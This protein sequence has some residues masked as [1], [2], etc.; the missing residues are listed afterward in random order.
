L[1][2]I[3]CSACVLLFQP[4]PPI[5]RRVAAYPRRPPPRRPHLAPGA[6]RMEEEEEE[7]EEQARPLG[8]APPGPISGRR[9]P[10][11][12]PPRLPQRLLACLGSS[13]VLKPHP[14][15]SSS[16]RRR[17]EG[18]V[19]R[20]IVPARSPQRLN[21]SPPKPSKRALC[22]RPG[23]AASAPPSP[24]AG[25]LTST[26]PRRRHLSRRI[27]TRGPPRE[28]R[29]WRAE[30]EGRQRNEGASL[31]EKRGSPVRPNA[32]SR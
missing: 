2:F 3:F 23:G 21:P 29:K 18:R 17:G 7:E 25:P 9:P 26:L 20:T 27:R 15:A 5:R 6:P 19:R 13:R 4:N 32:P 24:P 12:Y 11:C 30:P 28:N 22:P 16:P 31:R 8:L 1:F 14:K 10:P